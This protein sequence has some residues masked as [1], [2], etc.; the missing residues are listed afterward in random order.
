[1]ALRRVTIQDIAEA[2]G[3]SRNTVS[4]IFNNRGAVPEATKQTVL[5]KAQELGYLQLPEEEM[6]K[7][8]TYRQNIALLTCRMPTDYHFGTSFIPS[9]AGQLSRAGYTLMMYEL[10]VDELRQGSLPAHIS[11]DQTAGILGIELFDKDYIHKICDLGLPTIFVDGYFGANTALMNYDWISMENL[12]STK[13]LVSHVISQGARRIG[14]VGD[15]EHCNSFH[16][17]WY[18]FCSAL[19]SAGI[20]LDRELCILEPDSAPYGD[21]AWLSARIGRMPQM[22]EALI[23][24]NDFIAIHVMTA[25]K[26][27]GLSIPEQI[28][29]AGFDGTPQSA[30]VEPSLT[31]VQIPSTEIGR[32]A[33]DI[34]LTRIENPDRPFCCTYVRT[35]PLWRNSTNRN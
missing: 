4:K 17:R 7:P 3:L 8:E 35:T 27:M 10:S 31:T 19:A 26:Q 30:V 22:P 15:P 14:F 34:L 1:M 23:C 25:L 32:L 13:A 11:L 6:I 5:K 21:P 28:M 9:F 33:A 16:E 20:P 24:V 12:S 18:G 29:V 2:C